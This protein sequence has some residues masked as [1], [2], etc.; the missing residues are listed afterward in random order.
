MLTIRHTT[1][2]DLPTIMGIYKIAQDFMIKTGNPNQ[3]MHAHPAEELVKE[4]I[5]NGINRVIEE[6]GRICGVFALIEGKDPTY[7]YIEG[8]EWLNDDPYVTIHRIASDQTARGIF[9][10]AL[11]YCLTY[12][13]NVRIDTHE[14]NKVMQGLVEKNGFKKCGIIYLKNG[15]PRIAF[16]LAPQH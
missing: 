16:H 8:G 1:M 4:D 13:K 12:E 10:C 7:G 3:W 5:E 6:D 9:E 15:S 11:K 14:D 2:E